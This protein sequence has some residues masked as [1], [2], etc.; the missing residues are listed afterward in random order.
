MMPFSEEVRVFVKPAGLFSART[1]TDHEYVANDCWRNNDF[2][3]VRTYFMTGRSVFFSVNSS[4]SRRF[5]FSGTQCIMQL[6]PVRSNE[7]V[8]FPTGKASVV[9]DMG[10]GGNSEDWPLSVCFLIVKVQL[11]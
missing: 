2:A 5:D 6:P 3:T 4:E 1:R 9:T 10:T 8:K 11:L 7:T